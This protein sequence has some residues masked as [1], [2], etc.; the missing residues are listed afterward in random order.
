MGFNCT[1]WTYLR[2][3]LAQTPCT[4]S[5]CSQGPCLSC[6]T[7]YLYPAGA[8]AGLADWLFFLDGPRSCVASSSSPHSA[9]VLSPGGR[10]NLC[11]SPRSSPVSG[12][13]FCC[14]PAWPCLL[15][16]RVPCYVRLPLPD[17]S[18]LLKQ[19]ILLFPGNLFV[20]SCLQSLAKQVKNVAKVLSSSKSSCCTACMKDLV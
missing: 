20:M 15:W 9:L 6:V 12:S 7:L 19:L 11:H 13:G 3:R 2:S 16:D 1:D 4:A 8:P 5:P 18:L 14:F 10:L 17:T